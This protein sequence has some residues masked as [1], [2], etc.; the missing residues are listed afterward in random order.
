MYQQYANGLAPLIKQGL[1]EIAFGVDAQDHLLELDNRG[2][3]DLDPLPVKI[4]ITLDDGSVELYDL[5]VYEV[6]IPNYVDDQTGQPASTFA[7]FTHQL[8]T[9]GVNPTS[10]KMRIQMVS[11]LSLLSRRSR[12]ANE[13]SF[14]R[15]YTSN[16]SSLSLLPP[17]RSHLPLPISSLSK[18][19]LDS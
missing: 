6:T 19:L 16:P 8:C 3:L 5:H 13:A 15:I 9:F 10:M 18:L 12:S 17:F 1:P 7:F 11:S 14:R 2:Y 4:P